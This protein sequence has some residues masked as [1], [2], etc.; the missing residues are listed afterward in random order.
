MRSIKRPCYPLEITLAVLIPTP[1]E[2]P[3]R[4]G[5]RGSDLGLRLLVVGSSED[6]GGP[7]LLRLGSRAHRFEV[8]GGADPGTDRVVRRETVDVASMRI[9]RLYGKDRCFRR[10]CQVGIWVVSIRNRSLIHQEKN[11]TNGGKCQHA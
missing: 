2:S 7:R 11:G 9:R 10:K 6:G 3:E 5:E 4:T 1:G 8:E